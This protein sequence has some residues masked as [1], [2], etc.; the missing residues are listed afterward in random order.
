MAPHDRVII[1]AG[2]VGL[3]AVLT[4]N[5]SGAPVI[6]VEP[7]PFRRQMDQKLGADVVI[8]PRRVAF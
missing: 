1:F 7:Q 6:T 8:D 3:F 2:P 5:A 4:C